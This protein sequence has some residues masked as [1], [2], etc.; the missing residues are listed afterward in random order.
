MKL[1]RVTNNDPIKRL[2]LGMHVS[3]ISQLEQYQKFYQGTYGDEITPGHLVESILK[4]FFESDR[5]FQ[6]QLESAK[7]TG[8][9]GGTHK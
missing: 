1:G 2:S 6:K 4:K 7:A 3:M 8:P 5:E 9:A